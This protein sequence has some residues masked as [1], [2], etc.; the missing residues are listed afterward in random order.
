MQQINKHEREVYLANLRKGEPVKSGSNGFKMMCDLSERAM[1]IT[2][3]LNN[4]YHT[5]EEIR[6]LFSKLI[7]KPVPES[8]RMFPPFYTDCGCNITVGKNV[9]IN[10]C[11]NFQDQGGISIGDGS[12]IGHK[13]V[14]ATLNHGFDPEDRASLYPAPITIGKQVWIGASSTILPGVTIGDNAIIAAGSVVTKDVASN[15]LVAGVPA[16]FIRFI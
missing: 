3:A 5:A 1:Q 6:A 7:G 10:A 13:V 9:F 16:K 14:L 12:L 11:C 15:T 2:S 8:F 4:T